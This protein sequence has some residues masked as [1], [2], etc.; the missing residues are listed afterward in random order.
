MTPNGRGFVKWRIKFAETSNIYW[1][2]K[3]KIPLKIKTETAISQN[4]CWAFVLFFVSAF[5]F[6]FSEFLQFF[7]MFIFSQRHKVAKIL[8]LQIV[9]IFPNFHASAVTFCVFEFLNSAK[10]LRF[11]FSI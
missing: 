9:C 11:R 7:L 5:I 6:F 3:Y 8:L 2:Q 1:P 4:P 10:I